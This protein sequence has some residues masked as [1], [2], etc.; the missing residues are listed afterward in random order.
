MESTLIKSSIKIP[1]IW[2]AILKCVTG[3]FI[4]FLNFI[5]PLHKMFGR[6]MNLSSFPFETILS[7]FC[8][9]SVLGL[10]SFHTQVHS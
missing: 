7:A 2:S 9:Y 6:S 1:T 4:N 3:G 8:S 10:N 5:D